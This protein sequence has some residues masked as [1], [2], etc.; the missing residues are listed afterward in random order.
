MIL[1]ASRRW[2]PRTHPVVA[3]QRTRRGARV[4]GD[5]SARIARNTQLVLAQESGTT[6]VIDPWGGS[7]YVERSTY[8][9]ARRAWAHIEEVEAGRWHGEGDR[10]GSAEAADRGSRGP[11]PG[12]IDSGR[13]PVIGVNKY[14]A[15]RRGRRHRHPQG[16][17]RRGAAR[18]RPRNSTAA[19][20]TRRRRHRGAC[21]A[22]AGAADGA[23]AGNLLALAVDAAR[24]KATVGE[25][26]DALEKVYGRHRRRSGPSPACTARRPGAGVDA[27]ER[28]RAATDVFARRR[29]GGRGS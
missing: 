11:H 26:S 27:I 4:A 19:R 3:H 23:R 15:R 22:L 16:R 1:P 10:P 13:Q 8:D 21:D 9:L 24:A 28:A 17:Q 6:R 18:S 29:A 20:G 5:S 12:R 25:I 2:R 7:A 14:R